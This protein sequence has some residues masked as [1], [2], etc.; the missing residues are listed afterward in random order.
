MKLTR[1]E[2]LLIQAETLVHSQTLAK[3]ERGAAVL[4][5]TRE[6]IERACK[7]L[8]IAIEPVSNNPGTAPHAPQTAA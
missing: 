1:R 8:G 2:Q 6:R 4:P 3:W 5:A 7:T